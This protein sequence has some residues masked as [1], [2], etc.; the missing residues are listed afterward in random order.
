MSVLFAHDALQI[1]PYHRVLKDLNGWSSSVLLAELEQ[2]FTMAAA[3]ACDAPA[4]NRRTVGVYL[5]REWRTL[6]FREELTD[7]DV[8]A[9]RLDVA[10]LQRHVLAP[11]FGIDCPRTSERIGFVGGIRGPG[12]LERLVDSGAYAC[13]F[14]MH[15]TSIEE[16]MTVADEGGLMPP[17]STWFEPKLRDALFCLA[18]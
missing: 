14:A 8:P 17:K 5:D 7:T 1:L 13:A 15:P 2:V 9:E 6:Q 18:I 12:E 4:P 3:P 11:I 16:L 10:L